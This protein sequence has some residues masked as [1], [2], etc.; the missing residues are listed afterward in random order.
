MFA[1]SEVSMHHTYTCTH[2]SV[3]DRELVPCCNICL[4]E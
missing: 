2:M 1:D 4:C 3:T